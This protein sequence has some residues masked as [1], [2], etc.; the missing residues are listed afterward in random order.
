MP[1]RHRWVGQPGSRRLPCR[2]TP[3]HCAAKYGR[4][5]AIAELLMRGA[6][7]AVQD[8]GRYRCALRRTADRAAQPRA[9]RMTPK[10]WAEGRW[11]FEEYE[12]AERQV[13]EPARTPPEP[14]IRGE[15]G[16]ITAT[17]LTST[18][19]DAHACAPRRAPLH[20]RVEV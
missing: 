17:N 13:H 12:A 1:L 11:K 5:G 2:S 10:Q 8:N 16:C 9:R 6:D 15:E 4:T 3:L 14:A 20:P 7:G 19:T 18:V